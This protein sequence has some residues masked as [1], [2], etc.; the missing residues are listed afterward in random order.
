MEIGAIIILGVIIL[1]VLVADSK[2][3]QKIC[4]KI[5]NIMTK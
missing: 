2:I 1:S 4:N 5:F 3:G